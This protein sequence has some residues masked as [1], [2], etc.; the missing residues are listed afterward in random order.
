MG[1]DRIAAVMDP[2]DRSDID[3]LIA[4]LRKPHGSDV[5]NKAADLI[6]AITEELAEARIAIAASS[7]Q[8]I[9]SAIVSMDR[10]FREAMPK[11]NIADS[12]LD[13]NAFDAWNIAEIAAS[14]AM[15]AIEAMA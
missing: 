6:A 13:A 8:E 15:R 10:F 1:A 7:M 5:D 9:I 2:I 3:R 11:M 4:A 14:K 12:F